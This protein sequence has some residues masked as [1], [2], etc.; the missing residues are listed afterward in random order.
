MTTTITL[1]KGGL[2]PGDR[3]QIT[4][5]AGCEITLLVSKASGDVLTIR[6]NRWYWRTWFAVRRRAMSA[7][8]WMRGDL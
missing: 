7:R 5:S 1:A 6:P 8:R 3:I 2:E 4:T